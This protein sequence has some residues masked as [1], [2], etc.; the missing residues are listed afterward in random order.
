[1]KTHDCI[2]AYD[3]PDLRKRNAAAVVLLWVR[4]RTPEETDML[5]LPKRRVITLLPAVALALIFSTES[6]HAQGRLSQR[7]QIGRMCQQRA[8]NAVRQNALRSQTGYPQAQ[9]NA[10]QTYGSQAQLYAMQQYALQAQLNALQ[11]YAFFAQVNGAPVDDAL[12][13]ALY[14]AQQPGS[15]TPYQLQLLGQQ[16]PLGA[17][18]L[19]NRR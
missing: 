7:Q 5:S 18:Q 10:L 17:T 6:A 16:A 1:M 15:L 8:Q 4:N 19:R 12:L 9:L 14:A 13:M 2:P 11:Q 3:L